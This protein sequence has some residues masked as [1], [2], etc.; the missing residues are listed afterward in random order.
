MQPPSLP[1]A[2]LRLPIA[3]RALHGPGRPENSRA[4]ILSAMA[5]G[6]GIEIDVQGTADGQAVVFHDDDLDRLTDAT[7]PVRAR[8]A[9]ELA[10][11]RLKG[12]DETIPSLAEVL[13]LVAGR[14]PLLIEIKDQ[15]GAILIRVK[16]VKVN[17]R[18][19]T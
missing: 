7:G 5:A 19:S 2:F 17:P 15:T 9:Q 13:A 12:C 8:T 3:H 1:A 18:R 11:L 16:L 4:A 14:A 6:Y 10:A